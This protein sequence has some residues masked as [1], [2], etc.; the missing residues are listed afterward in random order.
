VAS[1]D[2]FEREGQWLL[3]CNVPT[4]VRITRKLSHDI[5]DS[6]RIQA[7]RVSAVSLMKEDVSVKRSVS[8]RS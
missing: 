6:N 4:S 5:R 3:E 1:P 8:I 2:V 7:P